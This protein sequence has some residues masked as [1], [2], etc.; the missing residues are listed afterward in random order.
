MRSY[1][2]SYFDQ[3]GTAFGAGAGQRRS[4]SV[5][6]SETIDAQRRPAK[7]CLGASFAMIC[8]AGLVNSGP[9]FAAGG[10]Y[11]VDDYEVPAPG[12][13]QIESWASFGGGSDRIFVVAPSCTFAAAP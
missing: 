6:P 13:C 7:R 5:M 9:A 11:V 10:P 8:L 1:V 4:E 2:I 3:I 12:E